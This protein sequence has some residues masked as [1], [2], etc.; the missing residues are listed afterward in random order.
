MPATVSDQDAR[1][2]PQRCVGV[3]HR[4]CESGVELRI[5]L[6]GVELPEHDLAVRPCQLEHAIR[7]TVILVLLDEMQ[8][9]IARFAGA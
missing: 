1:V 2:G 5:G 9:G 6:G 7:E 3:N 8:H 4:A